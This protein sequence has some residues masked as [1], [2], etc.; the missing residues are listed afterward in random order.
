MVLDG[1]DW[2]ETNALEKI[3]DKLDSTGELDVVAFAATRTRTDPIDQAKAERLSN[4]QKPES[5]GVYSGQDAIR[6]AKPGAG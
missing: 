4:F 2:L 1:D 5:E 6:R 3:A